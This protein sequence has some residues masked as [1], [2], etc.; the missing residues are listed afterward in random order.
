MKTIVAIGALALAAAGL[1]G[2][3]SYHQENA[4]L[5]M[6]RPAVDS[7]E[8]TAYASAD[9]DYPSVGGDILKGT[10]PREAAAY[11]A[12]VNQPAAAT[13]PSPAPLSPNP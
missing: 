6:P 10:S 4:A 8:L 5:R 3:V 11:D 1:G 7:P 13:T 9:P 12:T 2:C